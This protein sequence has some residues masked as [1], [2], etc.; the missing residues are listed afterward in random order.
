MSVCLQYLLTN[1]FMLIGTLDSIVSI[2]CICYII[3][4]RCLV[5]VYLIIAHFKPILAS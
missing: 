5:F 4:L 2:I 1:I 3:L